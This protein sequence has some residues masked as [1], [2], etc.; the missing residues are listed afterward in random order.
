VAGPVL[1]APK[2]IAD[3]KI[4]DGKTKALP[5][6]IDSSKAGRYLARL[7][8]YA[9]IANIV[10]SMIRTPILRSALLWNRE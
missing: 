9:A 4:R 3:T 1:A 8:I 2:T 7:I 5:R 10:P 6:F